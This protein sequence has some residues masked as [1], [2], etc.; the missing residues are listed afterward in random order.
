[1]NALTPTQIEDKLL[2]TPEE[3][4]LHPEQRAVLEKLA[5]YPATHFH[6]K[7]YWTHEGGQVIGTHE[8]GDPVCFT[9]VAGWTAESFSRNAVLDE[10]PR[11]RAI[12]R[13]SSARAE[14]R[15]SALT[16]GSDILTKAECIALVTDIFM[17]RGE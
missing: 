8:L 16:H 3:Q 17:D 1:M 15:M 5:Q 12:A 4:T 13:I 9:C 10:M 14:N 7:R 11:L 6:M 2:S